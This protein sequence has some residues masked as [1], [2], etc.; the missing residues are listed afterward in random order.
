MA[1]YGDKFVLVSGNKDVMEVC[2]HY[3]FTKAIHVEELYALM[4]VLS[5]L[6]KYDYPEERRLQNKEKVL[7]RFGNVSEEEL[8]S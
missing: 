2:K 8:V 5:P 6:A 3:G 4:P 7:Q 1:K